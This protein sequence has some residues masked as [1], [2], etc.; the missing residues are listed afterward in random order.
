M[1]FKRF[2][3]FF[4]LAVLVLNL[5]NVSYAV[6]ALLQVIQQWRLQICTSIKKPC[7]NFNSESRNNVPWIWTFLMTLGSFAWSAIGLG[8]LSLPLSICGFYNSDARVYEGHSNSRY[9]H[10]LLLNSARYETCLGSG[11]DLAVCK[12]P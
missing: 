1:L 8:G 5:S 6:I 10:G 4:L 3:C 7:W 12:G 11:A 2:Q 9:P